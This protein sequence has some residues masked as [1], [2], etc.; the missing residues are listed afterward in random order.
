MK[1][2]NL[3][4]H[5]APAET[6]LP[7]DDEYAYASPTMLT[8]ATLFMMTRFVEMP[9]ASNAEQVIQHLEIV[10]DDERGDP[11]MREVCSA[12]AQRWQGHAET[13]CPSQPGN[14]LHH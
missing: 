9:N 5:G 11:L 8:A 14:R 6:A 4:L 1:P 3:P 13:P 2:Q 12:L 10:A 7:G